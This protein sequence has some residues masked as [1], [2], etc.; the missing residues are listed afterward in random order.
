MPEKVSWTMR[1]QI[2]GGPSFQLGQELDLEAY[3]KLSVTVPTEGKSIEIPS[4]ATASLLLAQCAK[5]PAAEK[6]EIQCTLGDLE[7]DLAVAPLIVIGDKLITGLAA[8]NN[9]L[10]FTNGYENEVVIDILVCRES[11][12]SPEPEPQPEQP[13]PQSEQPEPQSEQP[14]PQSD[15]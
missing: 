2:K 5:L 12:A 15:E 11:P 3:A 10:A 4:L 6:K 7:L 9:S 13:E 14:E 1:L 8:G